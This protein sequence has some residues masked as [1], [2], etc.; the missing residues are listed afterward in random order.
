MEFAGLR[1]FVRAARFDHLGVFTYSP[2]RGTAAFGR[3]DNVEAEEKERRRGEIMDLQARLSLERN[4]SYLGRQVEV[5]VES[6]ETG[7]SSLWVGR[8]RFQAPEVDGVI[9]FDLPAGIAA[10]PSP[11]VRVEVASAGAYDLEG[12]LI[13]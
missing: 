9:R 10:P 11:I 3:P 4:R 5:L 13:P 6:R 12:K 7:D 2:E 8:G 1:N